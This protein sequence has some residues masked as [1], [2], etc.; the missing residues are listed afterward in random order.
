M[1]LQDRVAIVTGGNRGIGR[2]I[3]RRFAAEGASI[4]IAGRDEAALARTEREIA[5]AGGRV[6]AVPADVADEAACER[7]IAAALERFGALDILVNNAAIAS[8]RRAPFAELTTEVWQQTLGVNLDGMFYCGRAAARA[9]VARGYGRIVNVLAIQAWSPLPDNAPYAASKG[10]GGSLTRSMA[11]DLAPRGVIVNAIAPGP[12]YVAADEVP[13]DVDASAATLVRRAGRPAEVA[14]LAV[15][16][17]SEECSF[18]VGQT[19]ICDGGR[20][21]SRRG[22]PGWV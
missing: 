7:L 10:G 18:V 12:V 5:A 11:V 22:D 4:V 16:L 6:L 9:M 2:A 14:A 17:A 1:R 20:L 21:L 15:F 13:T 8:P 19:I 3:A